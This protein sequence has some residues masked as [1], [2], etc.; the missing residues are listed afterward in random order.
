MRPSRRTAFPAQPE[1]PDRYVG[2]E[3]DLFA[4]ASNWK[5]YLRHQIAPFLGNQVLEVG[6]GIGATTRAL[7]SGREQ[8]WG[9]LE[10]DA[11]L[12]VGAER[13]GLPACCEVVVGSLATAVADERFDSVLYVDVLE[14]IADDRGELDGDGED[15]PRDVP[16]LIAAC[17]TD[18][19]WRVVFAERIKRSENARFRAA[20]ATYR[21][22]HFALTGIRVRFGNFRVIPD[23]ALGRLVA[24]SDLWNHYAAA[25][26][27][28]RIPFFT[29][30]SAR[31]QRL[32][33]APRMNWI[34]LAVHGLSALSVFSDTIGVRLLI[35]SAALCGIGL[36][37]GILGLLGGTG[38]LVLGSAVLLL[39]GFELGSVATMTLFLALSSR[40]GTSFLPARDW[41]FFVREERPL[42][43]AARAFSQ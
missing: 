3:L 39:A 5:A 43:R 17:K 42:S 6:A 31:S 15:D 33:G 7:C 32:A 16:R 8:R 24:V 10:P 2:G 38:G 12:A 4:Q 25:V 14:H 40:P 9:C 20:Y 30:P 11:A 28:A 29:V 22:L 36:I 1:E 21:W 27:R 13:S 23:T 34:A 35:A 19:E 41:H 18:S 26:V 37:G